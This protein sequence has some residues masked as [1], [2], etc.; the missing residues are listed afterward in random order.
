M[1]WSLQ[2][3]PVL[4][5][6]SEVVRGTQIAS[7]VRT[8]AAGRGL[9]VGRL[10]LGYPCLP[11]FWECREKRPS[12]VFFRDG[13]SDLVEKKCAALSNRM[14]PWTAESRGR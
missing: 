3:Q 11:Y 13:I 4:E 14:R 1:L 8:S 5:A 7:E 12:F 2:P 6:S 9:L 10:F